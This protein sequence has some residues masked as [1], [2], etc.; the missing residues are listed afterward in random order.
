M[1][2]IT[3]MKIARGYCHVIVQTVAMLDN[4]GYK[5]GSNPQPKATTTT[6][7][8]IRISTGDSEPMLTDIR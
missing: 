3:R 8:T 2:I 7:T 6:T 4:S 1:I 5:R